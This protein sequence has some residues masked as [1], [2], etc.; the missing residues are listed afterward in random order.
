MVKE[1]RKLRRPHLS[2]VRMGKGPGLL[3]AV[4]T[5]HQTQTMSSSL[6]PGQAPAAQGVQL[7]RWSRYP[8]RASVEGRGHRTK[9]IS[10]ER[11]A[12]GPAKRLLRWLPNTA[13]NLGA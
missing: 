5:N 1:G 4:R 6:A 3:Q 13:L 9:R 7:R 8:P 2:S 11:N 10:T 12:G